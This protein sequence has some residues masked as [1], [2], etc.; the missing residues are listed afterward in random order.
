VL[1]VWR[2][3]KSGGGF[4]VGSVHG[5]CMTCQTITL[6]SQPAANIVPLWLKSAQPKVTQQGQSHAW[7]L[8]GCLR[9]ETS[10][11]LFSEVVVITTWVPLAFQRTRWTTPSPH[12][13][14]ATEQAVIR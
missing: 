8:M 10:Q 11:I 3:W 13:S 2:T 5:L 6:L 1:A 14:S 9:S 7:C 4:C 12:I